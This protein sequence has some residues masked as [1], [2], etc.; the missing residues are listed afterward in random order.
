[1][2]PN[3]PLRENLL[4]PV[5]VLDDTDGGWEEVEEEEEEEAP[6]GDEGATTEEEAVE[7]EDEAVA[8]LGGGEAERDIDGAA[9]EDP[10]KRP[11]GG[12]LAVAVG[13]FSSRHGCLWAGLGCS[14]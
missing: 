14:W 3:E 1:M 2:L 5:V 12:E 7:A 11:V 6:V 13:C 4:L 10:D 8:V 9:E